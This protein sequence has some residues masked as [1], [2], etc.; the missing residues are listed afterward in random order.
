MKRTYHIITIFILVLSL[1]SCED[2]LKETPPSEL[3]PETFLATQEG[4]EALLNNAYVP[5]KF[6][7]GFHAEVSECYEYCGDILFQT[8]GGM[9]KN[10]ILHSQ[11]QWSASECVATSAIWN[12]KYRVIRNA[13]IIIDNI[14]NIVDEDLRVQYLAEARFLRAASYYYLYEAYGPVPLRRTSVDDPELPRASEEEIQSFIVTELNASVDDLPFPGTELY[15]K[16]TKGAALGYLTRFYMLI[17]DWENAAATAKRVMDLNYYELFGSYRDLF[18]VENEPD[19]NSENKEMI[20]VSPCTNVD[21]GNSISACAMPPG[22][23]YTDKIPEF[24]A[25]GLANWASQFRFYD[26]FIET[27]DKEKDGRFELIFDQYV[28]QAGVTVDLT[29]NAN[30]LRSLKY[31]DNTATAAQHGN[32]FPLLRYADILML[33]AEALNELNGPTATNVALLNE[34][35]NRA[36]LDDIDENDFTKETLRDFILA[37]R[38]KEFYYEGLRRT[39]LIRHGKLIS[40]AIERGVTAA[41]D[42]H[43]LYPIPQA[44]IDAN[45]NISQEDQNTGY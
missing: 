34:V 14:E 42:Y 18:K 9:N 23:H 13:N 2:Y 44:E 39:D 12:P 16:A 27:F 20:M 3:S 33:R 10:F 25:V 31:F 15:G 26:S 43:I 36:G 4:V 35:L 30:N 38:G 24:E 7:Q 45:S 40:K 21:F 11:F 29:L 1:F 8:G 17:K 28:N 22:F 19:K 5:F 32:D 37:E 6:N 41:K